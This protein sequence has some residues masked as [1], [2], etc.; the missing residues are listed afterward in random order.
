MTLLAT[1]PRGSTA[2]AL[3][4]S[5][6]P[7]GRHTLQSGN[8]LFFGPPPWCSLIFIF[9]GALSDSGMIL[10]LPDF[11]EA[12]CDWYCF[13]AS[14][15]S[16]ATSA[17]FTALARSA[18]GRVPEVD[19]GSEAAVLGGE[20]SSVSAIG[21]R[22]GASRVVSDPGGRLLSRARGLSGA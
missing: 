13:T 12:G 17:T 15:R 9:F 18:G 7:F 4:F 21:V 3:T 20:L 19:G 6:W 10:C 5:E 14:R 8:V 2:R 16:S 11:V 1:F 22:E